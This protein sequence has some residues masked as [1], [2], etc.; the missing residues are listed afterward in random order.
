[1]LTIIYARTD[2]LITLPFEAI[3]D[4]NWWWTQGFLKSFLLQVWTEDTLDSLKRL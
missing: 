3:A 4:D 1:M 2:F